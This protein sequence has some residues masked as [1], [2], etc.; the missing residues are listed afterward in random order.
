MQEII[1]FIIGIIPPISNSLVIGP[2]FMRLK[3]LQCILARSAILTVTSILG[4]N[5][6]EG[7]KGSKVP[8]MVLVGI[9]AVRYIIMA[10][11]GALI[12]KYAVL[13]GLLHSDPLYKFV[14]LLQFTL[15]PAIGICLLFIIGELR[16][17]YNDPVVWSR[18]KRDDDHSPKVKMLLTLN[19]R[20][21]WVA[22]MGLW[23]LFS[24][25]L[26]P[27][28]N[29]L[30]ITAVGVFLAIQRVDILGADA[31]KHLNNFCETSLIG[32]ILATYTT[33]RSLPEL[34]FLLNV[35]ITFV[36]GSVLGWILVKITKAPKGLRG[37]IMGCCAAGNLGNMLVIVLAVSV[38]K[39]KGSPFGVSD[40]CTGN[41]M[42]YVSLSMAIGSLYIWSYV[43][44]IVRIYS[45][46]DSDE[47]KPDVVQ[48]G[49]ESAEEK[50][51][52][53]K[54]RTGPPLPSED[55]SLGESQHLELNCSVS[56]EKA[57]VPFPE[58]IKRS[59]NRSFLKFIK[60]P[61]IRRLFAPA[62]I[63][64]IV[65]L[66]IG[67]IPPFR[68]VLIGDS[69]PLHAV[70]D[71]ADMVGKAAIP[72]MNLIWG[73]NLLKGL[74]G[75]KVPLLVIIS[76]VAIRYIILPILGV[77]II[78]YAIHFGLVRSDPLYQLVLLLQ[79]ALPPAN[80]VG[81]LIV[82]DELYTLITRSPQ[83][84]TMSMHVWDEFAPNLFFR[85]RFGRYNE[86]VVW[87]WISECSV[88]MLWTNALATVSLTVWS[89]F[90]I[91]CVR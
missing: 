36:I 4:A 54:C 70:V 68:K 53:A 83:S 17:R 24:V 33:L 81:V 60:K 11:L 2:F 79:F 30:L 43:Y 55:P 18:Q 5:L 7:L 47:A 34:W 23:N 85:H 66:M 26:M 35:L 75:S 62:I 59:F 41:G 6:L 77:V 38:C 50:N 9:V 25:A 13:F 74:K 64:A 91:W 49:A 21:S 46:K 29:V 82:I 31:R 86:P 45:S 1:G 73:A 78:K 48:E 56:Q 16:S 67:I 32:S 28:L 15:P 14:L 87:S 12:I 8:P 58:N 88:I 69:A 42:A 52:S 27:V 39:E 63:G 65:G 72:I 57:K 19:L 40:V 44:N 3:T 76:I 37:V 22:A 80:S 90:F 89:T 61:S 51:E 10:I 84:S 20:Q 71:S